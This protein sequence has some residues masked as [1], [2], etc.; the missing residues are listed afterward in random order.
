MDLIDIKHMAC[1]SSPRLRNSCEDT[2]KF[3]V[4]GGRA[5]GFSPFEEFQL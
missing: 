2:A 3:D 5:A 4:I 1:N